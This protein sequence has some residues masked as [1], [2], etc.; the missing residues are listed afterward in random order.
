M[1]LF[2]SHG[3]AVFKFHLVIGLGEYGLKGFPVPGNLNLVFEYGVHKGIQCLV[4]SA[5]Q[6]NF[7]DFAESSQIHLCIATVGTVCA[8]I[9]GHGPSGV[10][11]PLT[12]RQD[13]VGRQDLRSVG[14]FTAVYGIGQGRGIIPLVQRLDKLLHIRVQNIVS[15]VVGMNIVPQCIP[16]GRL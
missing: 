3:V 16:G 10:F 11:Q 4:P 2:H 9:G 6:V 14:H 1:H 15:P 13:T 12:C 8:E 5:D 7:F